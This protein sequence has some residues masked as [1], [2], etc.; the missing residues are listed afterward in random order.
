[1]KDIFFDIVNYIGFLPLI[2]S[3]FHWKCLEKP[4]QIIIVGYTFI[5]L[6]S[7]FANILGAYRINNLFVFYILAYI[8][9]VWYGYFFLIISDDNFQKK[10]IIILTVFNLVFIAYITTQTGFNR[11]NTNIFI[12]TYILGLII[13][14]ILFFKKQNKLRQTL[15]LL[16]L[17]LIITSSYQLFISVLGNYLYSYFNSTFFRMIW[18]NLNPFFNLIGIILLCYIVILSKK[19]VRP[20]F[21]KMD[22]FNEKI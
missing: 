6:I 4:T 7:H 21:E 3:L 19:T 11:F 22:V 8:N 14:I 2:I 16:F 9:A 1:M 18:Y 12:G 13:P 17:Y 5:L 10:S 20:S 15:K